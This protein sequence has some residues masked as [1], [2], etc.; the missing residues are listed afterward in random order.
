MDKPWLCEKHQEGQEDRSCPR[1]L[2]LQT[3]HGRPV[4]RADAL[5]QLAEPVVCE[6]YWVYETDVDEPGEILLVKKRVPSTGI[7]LMPPRS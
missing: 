5:R 6:H 1:C 4:S 2:K 7:L 3:A